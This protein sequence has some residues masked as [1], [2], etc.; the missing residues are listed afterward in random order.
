LLTH[1]HEGIDLRRD[2]AEDTL[3][4]LVRIWRRPVALRTTMG[5]KP[6][7]WRHDGAAF[8]DKTE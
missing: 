8:E 1:R 4:N 2:Y 3:S 6:R 7:L 5:D